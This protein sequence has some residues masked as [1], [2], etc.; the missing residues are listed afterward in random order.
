MLV[1]ICLPDVWGSNRVATPTGSA[2]DADRVLQQELLLGTVLTLAGGY[3][4]RCQRGD[5]LSPGSS[6]PSSEEISPVIYLL[7]LAEQFGC[8]GDGDEIAPTERCEERLRL[9]EAAWIR[10]H[11]ITASVGWPPL[12]CLRF[13]ASSS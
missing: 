4:S 6:E 1:I 3:G 10:V 11:N 13:L 9:T 2:I 12:T 7:T 8:K 5:T